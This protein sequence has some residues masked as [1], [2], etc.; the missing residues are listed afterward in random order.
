[1]IVNFLNLQ[2]INQFPTIKVNFFFIFLQRGQ[3]FRIYK[4]DAMVNPPLFYLKDLMDEPIKRPYY[5]QELR[6]GPQTVDDPNF[7]WKIEKVLKKRKVRGELEYL[8]KY[9]YYPSKYIFFFY[10]CICSGL[11][12]NKHFL[13]LGKFNQWIK[14]TNISVD[15]SNLADS[16]V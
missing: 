7:E 13:F 8:V 3:L 4:V 12:H 9:E 10:P 5:R 1:M 14:A 11:I 15:N 16:N 6:L 2:C